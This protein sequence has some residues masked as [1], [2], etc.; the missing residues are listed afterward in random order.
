[1]DLIGCLHISYKITHASFTLWLRLEFCKTIDYLQI[2][3]K[4][5]LPK[6]VVFYLGY[7]RLFSHDFMAAGTGY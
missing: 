5:K 7:L 6:R 4:H 1:M 2:L 3:R